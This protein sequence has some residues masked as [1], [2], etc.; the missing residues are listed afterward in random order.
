MV[1]F[2]FLTPC[3][4]HF[5]ACFQNCRRLINAPAV[6]C[7]LKKIASLLRLSRFR[8]NVLGHFHFSVY[9]FKMWRPFLFILFILIV[10]ISRISVRSPGSSETSRDRA[11]VLIAFKW[12]SWMWWS[13]WWWSGNIISCVNLNNRA[14]T[15]L[16][17]LCIEFKSTA[18][19]ACVVLIQGLIFD[20]LMCWRL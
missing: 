8:L 10:M 4:F 1:S 20:G 19:S 12:R 18:F 7:N 17:V 14:N 15:I 2:H 5:C 13:L 16:D 11:Q 6:N 9:M 3:H